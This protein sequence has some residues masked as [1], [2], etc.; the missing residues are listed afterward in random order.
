MKNA[1]EEENTLPVGDKREPDS[2]PTPC[3]RDLGRQGASHSHLA[4]GA[5]YPA[6]PNT[7]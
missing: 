3:N 1:P 2:R 6:A 4:A 5:M 7:C